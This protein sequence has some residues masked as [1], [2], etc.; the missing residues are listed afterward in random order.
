MRIVRIV[1]RRV[2]SFLRRSNA[3]AEL[4]CEIEIH[5][6]QLTSEAMASGMAAAEAR[7]ALREFGPVR[8]DQRAVPR[9]LPCEV[10]SGLR[11][12]PALRP[13]YAVGLARL[14]HCRCTHSRLG[15]R[16]QDRHLQRRGCG[17]FAVASL[18]R[19]Q[20]ARPGVRCSAES[21]G[22]AIGHFLQG[23]KFR[24]GGQG[25]VHINEAR[26]ASGSA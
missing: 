21:A 4:Q 14:H 3:V 22:R 16:R 18:S 19:S 23:L 20:S 13:P 26:E 15:H 2:H 8:P 24:I 11:P 10:D 1:K 6:Q 17:P 5:I 12:G 25:V 7:A 9:H